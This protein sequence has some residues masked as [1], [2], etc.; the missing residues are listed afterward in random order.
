MK[1]SILVILAVSLIFTAYS[2]VSSSNLESERIRYEFLS[3]GELPLMVDRNDQDFEVSFIAKDLKRERI[4][5]FIDWHE[6]GDWGSNF[7]VSQVQV[8]NTKMGQGIF[9]AVN[10][11]A[12]ENTERAS[13]KLR[14]RLVERIDDKWVDVTHEIDFSVHIDGVS[15]VAKITKTKCVTVVKE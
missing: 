9:L 1:K 14:V 13:R 2:L 3:N 6:I 12:G 15:R 5:R 10:V 7:R 11:V 8:G 4:F